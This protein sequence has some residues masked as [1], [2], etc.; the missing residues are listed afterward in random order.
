MR[1]SL[2]R[3]GAAALVLGPALAGCGF[4]LAQP[5]SLG[6]RRIALQGFARDSALAQALRAALPR[7][8]SL[9]DTP[10]QAE[11]VLHALEDKLFRTVAGSTAIGQVRELRLR[12]LL[13]YRLTTPGG[14]TLVDDTELEQSR[15]LSYTETAALAKEAEEAALLREMRND[16][17]GQL[18]RMLATTSRKPVPAAPAAPGAAAAASAAP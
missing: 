4:R 8:V 9:V 2:L 17:A 12:V 6:Y 5:L 3:L 16:M 11:V 13:K 18:L 14:Q 1:R 10:A 7:G 15:D